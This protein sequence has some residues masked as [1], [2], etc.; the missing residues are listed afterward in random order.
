MGPVELMATVPPL[1]RPGPWPLNIANPFGQ[2][3][4][5]YTDLGYAG[6]PG[7]DFLAPHGSPFALCDGGVVIYAGLAG[8]AG[9]MVQVR[10]EWGITRYLHLSALAVVMGDIVQ[11]GYEGGLTGGTPDTYGAGLSTGPH[12][13]L[14]CYPDGEPTDNGYAGRVDASLY[15]EDAATPQEGPMRRTPEQ[16]RLIAWLRGWAAELDESRTWADDLSQTRVA[17]LRRLAIATKMFED[18]ARKRVIAAELRA[19]AERLELYEWPEVP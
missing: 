7:I 18:L 12:L 3:D 10:H 4:P 14:D 15:F 5:A 16:D 1:A 2:V 13:H 11:R 17:K 6:H 8:T 9:L 19:E